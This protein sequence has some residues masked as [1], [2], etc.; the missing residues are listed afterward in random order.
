MKYDTDYFDCRTCHGNGCDICGGTGK[1]NIS[2][3]KATDKPIVHSKDYKEYLDRMAD[4]LLPKNTNN[5]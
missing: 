2:V 3:H 4:S 5:D 1:S